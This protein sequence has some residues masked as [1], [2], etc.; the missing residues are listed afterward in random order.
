[1]NP[2]LLKPQSEI[3]AQVVVQGKVY[4]QREGARV[5]GAE[6]EAD[7]LRAGQLRPTAA[8]RRHRAGRRR[9]QRV[10]DQSAQE[11]HRQYGLCPRCRRSGGGDRRHRPRR[12]HR[13]SGRH[14]AVL[15]PKMRSVAGFIVNRFA[16]I[17]CSP[18]AWMRSPAHRLARARARPVLRGCAAAPGGRRLSLQQQGEGCDD[19]SCRHDSLCLGHGVLLRWADAAATCRRWA[20]ERPPEPRELCSV[21]VRSSGTAINTSPEAAGRA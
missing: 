2:V 3:G 8:R 4:R 13:E 7:A 14:Q 20:H 6:T 18:T 15:A 12:G 11:R 19:S 5:S 10:G 1:M 21:S 17:C 16:A 9:G